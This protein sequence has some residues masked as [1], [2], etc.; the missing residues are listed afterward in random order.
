[1]ALKE[2]WPKDLAALM[3]E[4]GANGLDAV[5]DSAGGDLLGKTGRILNYGAKVVCYGM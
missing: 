5:I 2:S 4:H 1:L 3:K